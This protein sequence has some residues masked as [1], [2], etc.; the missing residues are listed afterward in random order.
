MTDIQ[1]ARTQFSKDRFATECTG[2]VI[3]RVNAGF[4]KC[5]LQLEPKHCNA[6]GNPMGGAIFTL[7]DFAFAVAANLGGDLTVSQSSQITYLNSSKGD[8]LIAEAR[9]IKS[10]STTCFCQTTVSDDLG[11]LIAYVTTNGIVIQK[12]G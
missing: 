11:V 6:L 2:I 8:T 10:G 1:R 4:A 3:D 12:R 7:A 5:S 9:I